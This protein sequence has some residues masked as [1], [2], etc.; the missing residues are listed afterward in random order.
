MRVDSYE[1]GTGRPVLLLHGGAGPQSVTGFADLLAQRAPAHVIAPTHPGFGGTPRPESL[2]SIRGL[3]ELYVGMLAD[4]DLTDVT[5]IGNSIGGWITAEMALLDSPNN[6]S[7]LHGLRLTTSSIAR[8]ATM[9]LLNSCCT[10]P[11]LS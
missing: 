4:L 5:V 8:C 7:L 11:C 6:C 3:A 10:L 1:A 9:R 2:D